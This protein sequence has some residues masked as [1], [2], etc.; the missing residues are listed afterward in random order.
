M[1]LADR[2]RKSSKSTSHEDLLSHHQQLLSGALANGGQTGSG[3]RRRISRQNSH[4]N[5]SSGG[6]QQARSSR[7]ASRKA[8][9]EE[10][11]SPP[12]S[13]KYQVMRHGHFMKKLVTNLVTTFRNWSQIWSIFAGCQSN[14][15]SSEQ[16]ESRTDWEEFFARKPFSSEF[17]RNSPETK[18]KQ[19]VF[20]QDAQQS[21]QSELDALFQRDL[22]P[23]VPSD[24][25]FLSQSKLIDF[26]LIHDL[27]FQRVRLRGRL[28]VR[29]RELRAESPKSPKRIQRKSELSGDSGLGGRVTRFGRICMENCYKNV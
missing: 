13:P 2:S 25:D 28:H 11:P 9:F 12:R 7:L 23:Q 26:K 24:Q 5:S 10:E 16:P 18:R 20:H 6:V 1:S 8:S 21:G 14:P 4:S 3:V 22:R 17:G 15:I 29:R 27:T 19:S